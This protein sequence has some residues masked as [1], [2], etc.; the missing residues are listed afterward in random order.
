M[1]YINALRSPIGLESS[2]NLS[3]DVTTSSRTSSSNDALT[4]RGMTLLL[5]GYSYGSLI[6]SHLPTMEQVL[7]RFAKTSRGTAED[8]I[9]LRA[10]SLSMQWNKEADL[11][12]EVRGRGL[13]S[14][15]KLGESSHSIAIVMGGEATEPGTNRSSRDSKRSFDIIRKSVDRS[16]RRLALRKPSS[17]HESEPHLSEENVSTTEIPLPRVQYL[18]ISPLLP[19]ISSLA[20]MFSKLDS[21]FP[22]FSQP[23]ESTGGLHTSSH[24]EHMLTSHPTL[25]V[26]G[27]NDFFTSHKKLRKWAE[28][29]VGKPGSNFQF[30]EIAGA[31]HFWQEEGVEKLMRCSIRE[32][33]QE[34][35]S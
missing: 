6:T 27:G 28:N 32:W 30:R 35:I 8:E 25:A 31:G 11:Q 2:Q 12:S 20:T 3:E 10:L 7:N 26:Y 9:R 4:G 13:R 16:R 34:F 18:L 22:S 21:H 29:L 17:G 19:P 24:S 15:E 14:K 5:G 1:Q 33:L 23:H